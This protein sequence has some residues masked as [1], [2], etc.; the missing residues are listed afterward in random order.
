MASF[1]AVEAY[2]HFDKDEPDKCHLIGDPD[3]YDIGVRLGFYL[4]YLALMI[5]LWANPE[6]AN[7]ARSG[8][9][10]FTLEIFTN[11]YR[12]MSWEGSIVILEILILGSMTIGLTLSTLPDFILFTAK[13]SELY[14]WLMLGMLSMWTLSL[15]WVFLTKQNNGLKPGCDV[16]IPFL[17]I[18]I[19]ASNKTWQIFMKVSSCLS[20]PGAAALAIS[21]SI[22][23]Y[24]YYKKND[25]GLGNDGNIRR[26]EGDVNIDI[27]ADDFDEQ[28]IMGLF[29]RIAFLG[30]TF[31]RLLA[32]ALSIAQV[33][34]TIKKNQIDIS[35][36][37]ITST[38]QFIPLLMGVYC[39]FGAIVSAVKR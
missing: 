6:A 29:E 11:A 3:V 36:A 16:S 20:I 1:T 19:K 22:A 37:P 30:I 9:S 33:E 34:H 18:S 35:S 4:Q 28:V 14:L 10:I 2:T 13:N 38:G 26:R 8:L 32:T 21:S 23:L 5:H 27:N 25:F 7:S 12:T 31:F 17:F 24:L 39:A 15:P